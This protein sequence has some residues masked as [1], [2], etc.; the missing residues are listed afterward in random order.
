M[1]AGNEYRYSIGNIKKSGN[2]TIKIV[3]N[4]DADNGT[5][6]QYRWVMDNLEWYSYEGA[7]SAI[8]NIDATREIRKEMI[9]GQ[10]I[11]NI[12]GVRYN[13]QGQQL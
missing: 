13:M 9:N 10:L 3:N 11:I 1:T 4:N 5:D 2:F 7:P 8:N 6:N 12:D